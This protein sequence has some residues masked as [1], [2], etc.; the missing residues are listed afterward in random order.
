MPTVDDLVI[1]LRID[2]SSNLGKLQKQLTAL[3]GEKGDK[4]VGIG[5]DA[6]TKRD[7][8]II[9]DRIVKFTPSVLMD[10]NLKEGALVLAADL[11]KDIGL[12][13][14]L[15][16]K[17]SINIV[18]YESLLDELINISLGISD[19]NS[20]QQK[21]FIAEM[22]K[23]R[24]LADTTKGELRTTI[25]RLTKMILEKGFHR[26]VV[27][28]LREAGVSVLSKPWVHQITEESLG[29]KM[30]KAI[31]RLREDDPVKFAA[32][33][34]I[35]TD[36]SDS[37]EATSKAYKLQTGKTLDLTQLS[38]K[39]IYDTVELHKIIAAQASVALTKAQWMQDVFYRAGVQLFTKTRFGVRGGAQLDVVLSKISQKTL[40]D[41][42]IE[43][44][45]GDKITDDMINI[46]NEYKTVLTKGGVDYEY[47]KR[48]VKQ[49]ANKLFYFA[50]EMTPDALERIRYLKGLPEN[51]LKQ[52]GAYQLTPRAVEILLGTVSNLDE[53]MDLAE[54][55]FKKEQEDLDRA[56]VLGNVDKE[57]LEW[58][59]EKQSEKVDD[60][61]EKLDELIS[62][63][64]MGKST[65]R[66][67]SEE[68]KQQKEM[69]DMM[70]EINQTTK[71][72]Y[73]KVSEEDLND[74][75]GKIEE[76]STKGT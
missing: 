4:A 26:R 40:K 46:L 5:L 49:N 7:L 60:A 37:L 50:E 23:F 53:K 13:N 74:T 75:K 47:D 62:P 25:T 61:L 2:E 55:T 57:N 19:L 63:G 41:L 36:N 56:E 76:D 59:T 11:K 72:T 32:L 42:G 16:Q 73:E 39:K 48:I 44:M 20:D 9:K 54:K 70:K 30:D 69:E 14:Q 52:I 58:E 64:Q 12:R 51:E 43:H 68:E 24:K 31:K 18:K 17:Y 33:V 71:A 15:I 45:E 67:L 10:A 34:K 3:V 27:A 21:I 22:D 6:D 66:M 38:Q 28:A 1:S 35:F 29:E 8:K 65:E